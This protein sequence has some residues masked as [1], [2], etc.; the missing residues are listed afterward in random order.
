MT[1]QLKNMHA[2]AMDAG[3]YVSMRMPFAA[4]EQAADFVYMGRAYKLLPSFKS[5]PESAACRIEPKSYRRGDRRE[6]VTPDGKPYPVRIKGVQAVNGCLG[7][8]IA[9]FVCME[10]A[11]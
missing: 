3:G 6:A 10:K 2:M 11:T 4:N 1:I 8:P 5:G 7:S 9:W